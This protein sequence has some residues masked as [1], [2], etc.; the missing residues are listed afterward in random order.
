MNKLYK[1]HAKVHVT[2]MLNRI[3]TKLV[4]CYDKHDLRVP[5]QFQ[6]NAT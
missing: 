3:Q 1:E 6:H 4:L 5:A 2:E